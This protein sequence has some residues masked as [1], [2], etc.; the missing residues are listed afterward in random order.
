MKDGHLCFKNRYNLNPSSDLF[1]N[2]HIKT[3][4]TNENIWF[5]VGRLN[6]SPKILFYF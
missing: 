2:G 6:F 1:K 5:G 3:G 4:K